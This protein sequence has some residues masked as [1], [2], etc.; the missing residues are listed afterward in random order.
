MHSFRMLT[1][2]STTRKK[3]INEDK[4]ILATEKVLQQWRISIQSLLDSLIHNEKA[5]ASVLSSYTN[6]ENIGMSIYPA[7][8]TDAHAFLKELRSPKG[9]DQNSQHATT[10][11]ESL[12][13]FEIAKKDLSNL[14]SRIGNAQTLHK[15][16]VEAIRQQKYYQT[17]T[18]KI[19]T[20]QAKRTGPSNAKVD[21]R[22][23]RNLKKAGDSSVNVSSTSSQLFAELDELDVERLAVT[24]RALSAMIQLQRHYFT[25]DIIRPS[26]QLAEKIG[27]GKRVLVRDEKKPWMVNSVSDESDSAGHITSASDASKVSPPP[28]NPSADPNSFSQE[29]K[30]EEPSSNTKESGWY[31]VSP[32][33]VDEPSDSNSKQ[34]AAAYGTPPDLSNEAP[35]AP[36]PLL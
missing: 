34:Q 35:A 33:N 20:A 15:K 6:F 23:Q 25:D 28:Y 10:S 31:P 14:L 36:A 13:S 24:D 5:W 7:C 18:Q 21:D 2:S 17:K 1:S 11:S 4:S 32:D 27:L 30:P 16:R 29:G 9:L 19:D 26:V 22:R 12:K 8:D 3:L